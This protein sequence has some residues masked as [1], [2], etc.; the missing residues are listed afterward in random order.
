MVR[1]RTEQHMGG[2]YKEKKIGF[3]QPMKKAL[4]LLSVLVAC[5]SNG[6]SAEDNRPNIVWILIDDMSSH[7]GFGC[8][9]GIAP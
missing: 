8:V 7:I 3:H 6:A 2:I 9:V 5:L 1:I 4:L